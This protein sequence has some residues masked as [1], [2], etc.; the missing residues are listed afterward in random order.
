MKILVV[1]PNRYRLLRPPPVGASIVARAAQDAGHEVELLDLMWADDARASLARALDELEPDLVGFNL[2]NIDNQ[3]IQEPRFFIPEY[4]KLVAQ[5]NE[6]APTVVG[7]TALMAMP[8][9]VFR[10]SG[11]TYG[12]CGPAAKTF[13]RWL[14]ELAA[15][16]THFET[17]GAMWLEG[18]RLRQNPFEI[19]AYGTEGRIGW[20]YIDYARYR[21]QEMGACIITKSGC[22]YRCLFCDAHSR[23]GSRFHPRDPE[24][25]VEEL[26]ADAAEHRHHRFLYFFID[27]CFNEPIDWAKQLCEALIRS[28][29]KVG[30]SALLEPTGDTDEELVALMRRAGCIMVSSLVGSLDEGMQERLQRPGSPGDIHRSFGLLEKNGIDYMPQL[31]LGGPGESKETVEANLSFLEGFRP[32]MVDV[33]CGLRIMPGADLYQVALDEGVVDADTDMLEPRFYLSE[34]LDP[35]W[36]KGRVKRWKRWRM[37]PLWP[38]TRLVARSM[39]LRF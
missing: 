10:A 33:G 30:W 7:G 8:E 9:E 13:P 12:L 15:G 27:P 29:L 18:D 35:A 14:D 23:F 3:D 4:A 32:L 31:L 19:D 34:R 24:L 38:W 6:V 16:T 2:R 26:R 21:G 39:A 22:P 1:Y 36:L 25:V 20:R 17:P 5:A 11:A 37:P 28:E